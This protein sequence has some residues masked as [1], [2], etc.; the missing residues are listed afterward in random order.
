M[1]RAYR[2][3]YPDSPH[4]LPQ[5]WEWQQPYIEHLLTNARTFGRRVVQR[6]FRDWDAYAR[7]NA[8]IWQR[9]YFSKPLYQHLASWE[10]WLAEYA[11][12][13]GTSRR[14]MRKPVVQRLLV[15][16]RQYVKLSHRKGVAM[17]SVIEP[18]EP[19]FP[20][21]GPPLPE[22]PEPPLPPKTPLPRT[23]WKER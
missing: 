20:P 17:P 8:H 6:Y 13:S 14:S 16:P 23:M 15:H 10:V 4:A 19:P 12:S 21:L 18:P 2:L 22:P 11:S 5:L 1:L 9:V 7:E 3:T